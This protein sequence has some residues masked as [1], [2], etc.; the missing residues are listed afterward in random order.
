LSGMVTVIVS[1]EGIAL[2]DEDELVSG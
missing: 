2:M 1:V